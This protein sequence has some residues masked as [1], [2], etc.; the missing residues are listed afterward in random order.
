MARKATKP[1]T[2]MASLT[3][4]VGGDPAIIAANVATLTDPRIRETRGTFLRRMRQ[5]KGLTRAALA[6]QAMATPDQITQAEDACD[7]LS[8]DDH[9]GLWQDLAKALD[10]PTGYLLMVPTRIGPDP[11]VAAPPTPTPSAIVPMRHADLYPSPFNSRKIFDAGDLD[12]L[13]GT[14]AAQGLLQ[15]LVA[16]R[17]PDGRGEIVAGE[18]RW[19]AIGRLIDRGQ[20]DAAA[21]IPVMLR[22]MS[23]AEH[24]AAMI[25][26]NLSRKDPTP[27]EE[28]RGFAELQET[29]PDLYTNDFIARQLG[30]S[31]RM[32]QQRLKLLTALVPEAIAAL[33][34]GLIGPSM[35]RALYRAPSRDMQRTVIAGIRAGDARLQ[36]VTGI[37]DFVKRGMVPVTRARFPIQMYIDAVEGRDADEI[38]EFENGARYMPNRDTFMGLQEWWCAERCRK[39]KEEG[40]DWARVEPTFAHWKYTVTSVKQ[41]G[42]G[43]VLVMS[44]TDGSVTE[45]LGLMPVP[46]KAPATTTESSLSAMSARPAPTLPLAP[47]PPA[48]QP[49]LLKPD[50]LLT[51]AEQHQQ[52]MAME[53][54]RGRIMGTLAENPGDMMVL[55]ILD[56]G[57]PHP[58]S[59]FERVHSSNCVLPVSLFHDDDGEPGPLFPAVAWAEIDDETIPPSDNTCVFTDRDAMGKALIELITEGD[60]PQIAE[61]WAVLMAD[62]IILDSTLHPVWRAYATLR[63]IPL[64]DHLRNQGEGQ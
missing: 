16:R 56:R 63:H 9:I 10:L 38:V 50:P 19:R 12:T 28:A 64:P 57:R 11:A 23:D 7:Q 59:L 8:G 42:A 40:W 13:A 53:F 20:W 18:R 60:S 14:I 22:D 24:R 25:I 49:A 45:H 61:A 2:D 33:E 3:A 26:E 43:C 21:P 36:T 46:A 1:A 37:E 17:R 5:E 47:P 44:P 41:P 27:L 54:F 29:D 52:R 32:V 58:E 4:A 55:M 51:H 34:E 39:L 48:P 30:I 35:A 62:T 6:A 31:A 15:N